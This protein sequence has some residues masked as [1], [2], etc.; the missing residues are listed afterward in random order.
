V[1]LYL[2]LAAMLYFRRPFLKVERARLSTIKFNRERWLP[3]AE[4]E[5]ITLSRSAVTIK[6]KGKRS[7][8]VFSR[9]I[10]RYDT[11]AMGERLEQFGKANNIPVEQL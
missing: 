9:L 10:N 5:K 3:A 11:A 6:H 4:I 7:T 2:L 1:G 8:W